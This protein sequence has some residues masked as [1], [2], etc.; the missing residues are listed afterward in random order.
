MLHAIEILARAHVV[1]ALAHLVDTVAPPSIVGPD[2]GD[3]NGATI[4]TLGNRHAKPV[5]PGAAVGPAQAAAPPEDQRRALGIEAGG[6]EKLQ[7]ARSSGH[8]QAGDTLSD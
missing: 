2:A 1:A 4:T 5:P 3:M 6:P 8:P 7:V